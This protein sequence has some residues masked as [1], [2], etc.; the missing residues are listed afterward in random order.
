[1]KI[2]DLSRIFSY[3]IYVVTFKEG[4][5]KKYKNIFR[6]L[7]QTQFRKHVSVSIVHV[8]TLFNGVLRRYISEKTENS[9]KMLSKYQWKSEE[10]GILKVSGHREATVGIDSRSIW[11]RAR[12]PD[13][14]LRLQT[15]F[16]KKPVYIHAYPCI[17]ALVNAVHVA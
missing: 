14:I 16:K 4:F 11:R 5:S 2:N 17:S 7:F 8:R 12:R 6:Y 15:F 10:S 9:R 13:N 3:F 1:M